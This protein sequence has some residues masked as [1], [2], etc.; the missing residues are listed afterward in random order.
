VDSSLCSADKRI[1]ISHSG[2]A[3]NVALQMP[4]GGTLPRKR[5]WPMA[6]EASLASPGAPLNSQLEVPDPIN[7]LLPCIPHV[8]NI[9]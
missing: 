8:L 6:V 1:K 3:L 7:E 2:E 5:G 4:A 9:A